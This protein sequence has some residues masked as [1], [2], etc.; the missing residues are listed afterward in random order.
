M[1]RAFATSGTLL[2]DAYVADR[3]VHDVGALGV[4]PLDSRTARAVVAV[5]ATAA[6]ACGPATTVRTLSDVL[7]TPL[8]RLLGFVV[9]ER[10]VDQRQARIVLDTALGT[11]VALLL[12]PWASSPSTAWKDLVRLARPLGARWGFVLAPPFLSLAPVTGRAVRHSLDLTLPVSAGDDEALPLLSVICAPIFDPGSSNGRPRLDSIVECANRY[13]DHVR[14]D[15]QHGVAQAWHLLADA[16]SRVRPG[17]R[18][19][20]RAR[21]APAVVSPTEQALTLVYRVLFLLFVESRALVPLDNPIYSSAYSISTLCRDALHGTTAGSWDALAAMSRLARLGCRSTA[22]RSPAFNGRLF[23]RASAPVLESRRPRAAGRSDVSQRDTEVGRALVALASR[24]G[25]AG[26]TTINYRDLGV[27]QLGAVYERLLD[28]DPDDRTPSPRSRQTHSGARK[29]TGTFYTPQPLA[30]FVVRRTLAPLVAGASSDH[31][32]SLRVVDPAMGSGACLVAACR[33]LAGAVEQALIEEGRASPDD[34]DEGERADLRRLVAERC[35]AG[36]DLNPTAVELARLSL[37][38]TT[39]AR[40][41][42]LGFLDHRLR[43]GNSLV[44]AWPEDLRRLAITRRPAA[45]GLPLF[46]QDE[47]EEAVHRVATPLDHLRHRRDDTVADVHAKA[48]LWREVTA[49]SSPLEPWR[50]AASLWCARWFWPEGEAP[51]GTSEG[52]ALIDALLHRDRTLPTTHLAVRLS[53]TAASEH[54]HGFFHWPLEFPEVFYAGTGQAKDAAG[55]DAVIGNP[56]WEMLRRDGPD[57]GH[58]QQL[59]RYVRESG[60]YPSCGRGHLNLYQ[61]FL[62]RAVSI[63]RPGGRVGLVLPWSVASDDGAAGLRQRLLDTCEVDT[64]V[65]IDNAR[66]LFPIH[67]GIRMLVATATRGRATSEV[68]AR[69]GLTRRE[70]LDE[71]PDREDGTEVTA[72]PVRMTPPAIRTVGGPLLRIPD[73]RRPADF[74][75]LVRLCSRFPRL[76]DPTGWGVTFGR[77]L[78]ATEARSSMGTSGMPVVE[79]KHVA[80]FSVSTRSTRRITRAAALT[81]LPRAPFDR[82]RLAYRDV[83]AVSNRTTFI[84]AILPAGVVSTH[85]LLCLR[86]ALPLDRQHFLCGLFNSSVL[87]AVVRM[88][89]GAH[90]TTTLVEGLPVPGWHGDAADRAIV[91]AAQHLSRHGHDPATAARLDAR[92]AHTYGLSADDFRHVLDGF[93]LVPRSDR[94]RALRAFNTIAAR[95]ASRG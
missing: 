51:P 94:D 60:Q 28:V 36:V 62:D 4:P 44:G 95:P 56:P 91:A 15:L 41:K 19:T 73:V 54:A 29:R 85:T 31:I 9:R 87:N 45:H 16:V 68:R 82:P 8:M 27:E 92:V 38:L 80:P 12:L 34:F 61:A 67:R 79:G 6:A 84:A 11:P 76:D 48:A 50:R 3:L 37:W 14:A 10:S 30:E 5:C 57:G 75:W 64:L 13:Q 35:L 24:P 49:Q 83:S 17:R 42:P 39:L 7:A 25:A 69:F 55:F 66:A 23:A 46:D 90:V 47:L 43:V 53:S 59:L 1:R 63:T 78:N 2:P 74:D 72:Y 26:R 89:M 58:P 40:G 32:L 20:G 33:Y 52:R 71:L 86:T 88:L 65:G 93:P 21:R 70:E 81:L 18:P 22:L 77:E